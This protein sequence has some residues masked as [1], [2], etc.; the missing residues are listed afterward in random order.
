[1]QPQQPYYSPPTPQAPQN[2]GQYDFIVNNQAPRRGPNQKTI[3]LFV[4]GAAALVVILAWVILGLAFGGKGGA[5]APL[6]TLA[7]EQTEMVRI[8]KLANQSNQLSSQDARNF[9]RNTQLTLTSDQSELVSFLAKNGKKLNAKQ[10]GAKQSATTDGALSAASASG[11]YDSTLTSILQT[12]LKT[13]QS[14]LTQA[15]N[16]ASSASEKALLKAEF[17]HATLLYEQ[18]NQ[19]N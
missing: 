6:V 19:R 12:Q 10:L 3:I 16:G 7:Q 4:V 15:Y 13:Y 11:T 1:M 5:T 14:N 2:S 9:S 8:A 17:D 18:S